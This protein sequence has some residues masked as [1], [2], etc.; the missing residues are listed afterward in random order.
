[1]KPHRIL[2]MAMTDEQRLLISLEARLSKYERDMARARNA[3]ND[4][5]RRMERRTKQYADNTERV[6]GQSFDNIGKKIESSFAPFLRGGVVF[7]GAAAAAGAIKQIAGSIAE[8]DREARKAGVSARV[9]Q[10]WSYVATAAGASI[11]GITDALKELNI[12]GD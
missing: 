4:N 10:Q 6:L 7:A 1:R 3:T 8:V 11:D 9:W 5:F 2:D 12:R